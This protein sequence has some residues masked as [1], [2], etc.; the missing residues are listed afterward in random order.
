LLTQVAG[1]A[2]R[3]IL[4][5]KVIVQTY[6]PNHYCIQAASR[7]DF[8]GFYQQEVE[9]RRQQR[10]PPFSRLV[11]LMYVHR[12]A[13]QA[14]EE[15]GRMHRLLS[16]KIARLG[17][18]EID[19]LGPAPAFVSRLRGQYRWQIIVRGRDPHELLEDLP[20]PLGG[21]VDV[22]PASLL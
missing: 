9:F 7:H 10:Y 11:R 8:E 6:T 18:P 14:Q 5:G 15:A 16:N 1:R 19:L 17:L 20:L 12:N 2:G 21:R 13:A 22:D 3:S 4:G